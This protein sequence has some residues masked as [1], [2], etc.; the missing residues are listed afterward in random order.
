VLV[1]VI[2]IFPGMIAPIM[3]EGVVGKALESGVLNLRITDLRDFCTDRHRITDDYPFGGGPGL[4]MK[5]EPIFRA[6]NHLKDGHEEAITILTTPQGERFDQQMAEKLSK[7]LHLIVFCGRYR[8][9]DERAKE[10]LFDMEVSIGEYVLSG[11]ELAA[12]VMLDAISRLLPGTLG[13]KDS[14]REETFSQGLLD[15]PQYT[16]PREYEGMSVPEVLLNGDHAAIEL[17]RKQM[18]LSSTRKHRPDLLD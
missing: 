18:A 12:L 10:K 2:T 3:R 15:S 9:V 14:I 4:L 11:G 5:P 1:D 17:W 6:I 16:R 8:G 7:K 13:N